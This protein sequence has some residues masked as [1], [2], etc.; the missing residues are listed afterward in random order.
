MRVHQ[1]IVNKINIHFCQLFS[2][3]LTLETGTESIPK[4]TNSQRKERLRL[5]IW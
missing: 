1:A 2:W 3:Y 4:V 5:D